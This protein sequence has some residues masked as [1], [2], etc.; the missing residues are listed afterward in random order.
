[1]PRVLITTNEPHFTLGLV[2]G[3]RS[4]GWDVVTGATNFRIRAACYDVVHHQWP[5]EFSDWG[6]PSAEQME[7]I[8]SQLKW[9]EHRAANIFTVNNLYPHQLDNDPACHELYSSFFQHCQLITHYTNASCQAVRDSFPLA[10]D[11]RHVVHTPPNYEVTLATQVSRGSQ[12]TRMGIGGHEFV[13]LILGSIRSVEE[14]R[15][16][17]QAYDLARVDNKRLLMAGKLKLKGKGLHKRVMLMKW[18]YWLWRRRAVVDVRYVPESEMFQ[19]MDSCDVIIV[20]RLSGLNS[21]LIF[22][23]MTF[24]R[25]ILAPNRS[26]YAECMVGSRN[27][28]YDNGSAVALAE[29]L[30]RAS[31]IDLDDIG[32]ENARIASKWTWK[33]IV[34]TCLRAAGESDTP[35]AARIRDSLAS[36]CGNECAG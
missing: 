3:Y 29:A 19:F 12:R 36:G 15:L 26:S 28:L 6:A 8:R 31:T 1:M 27:L 13:I 34:Q 10:R 2:E 7:E 11:V 4:L 17:Q 32:Q 23:G 20:P 33:G 5:E 22:L 18:R 30:E 9:W 24:G 14:I 35:V 21:A 25:T 16:I